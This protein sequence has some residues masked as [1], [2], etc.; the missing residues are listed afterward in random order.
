MALAAQRVEA[1]E[2]QLAE[3]EALPDSRAREVALDAVTGLMQVYGDAL[4]QVL[5]LAPEVASRLAE[6]ELLG[7]LLILHGLH[8][9]GVQERVEAALESV[10][11]YLA[12]HGGNVELVSI[13]DGAVHLRLTGTC[14]GCPSSTATLR[15]AIEQ[16]I[17]RFAPDVDRVDAQG[18]S[19]PG[20][21]IPLESLVCP[22]P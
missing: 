12:T 16:A 13:A 9:L 17:A 15:Q 20:R 21:V 5:D 11:P 4:A 7:Q 18:A 22:L 10:R 1:L 14:N 8:P 6:D 19:A 3:I 2:R